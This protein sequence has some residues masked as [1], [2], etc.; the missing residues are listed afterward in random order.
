MDSF[1]LMSVNSISRETALKILES[2]TRSGANTYITNIF[3]SES[4]NFARSRLLIDDAAFSQ[5]HNL[6]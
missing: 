2:L 6:V 3:S 5:E 1:Q 4:L